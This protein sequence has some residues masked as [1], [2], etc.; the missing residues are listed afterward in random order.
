MAPT[1]SSGARSADPIELQESQ[2]AWLAGFWDGEGSIGILIDKTTRI[3]VAQ[4]SHTDRPSVKHV[5]DL[6]FRA[7][8][9]GRGYTYQERDPTKHRDAHYLRVTGIGNVRALALLLLPFAVTKRRH[10]ELAIEWADS[11]IAA[12]GGLDGQHLKRGGKART[13]YSAREQEVAAE[14]RSLNL[15]GPASRVEHSILGRIDA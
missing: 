2:A 14:L 4:M 1:S 5:L 11:R 10:W 12:A 6:L 15:R 8:I 3:L 13:A 9:N 7:G